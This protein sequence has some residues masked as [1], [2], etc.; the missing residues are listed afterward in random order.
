MSI[1]VIKAPISTM[2]I[3]GFLISFMGFNLVIDPFKEFII[4]FLWNML[5]SIFMLYPPPIKLM[6]CVLHT[7]I[8]DPGLVRE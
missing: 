1:V 6:L 8:D 3:T 2:N 7:G 5:V 4:I